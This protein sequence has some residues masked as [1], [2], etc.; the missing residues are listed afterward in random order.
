MSTIFENTPELSI[1]PLKIVKTS[2]LTSNL[3]N[4]CINPNKSQIL[5][6]NNSN[7]CRVCDLYELKIDTKV[8]Y[9]DLVKQDQLTVY[10]QP[11]TINEKFDIFSFKF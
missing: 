10:L 8:Q 5:S 9:F 2:C 11:S 4:I 6:V 1:T 3:S 7:L